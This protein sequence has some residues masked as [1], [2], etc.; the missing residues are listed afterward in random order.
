MDASA[1]HYAIQDLDEGME[2]AQ[3]HP[4]DVKKS[5]YTELALDLIQQG[6]GGTDSWGATPLKQYMVSFGDK[7]FKFIIEPED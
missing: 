2:K 3:R 7:T 1:L 4:Q 6:V 5:R